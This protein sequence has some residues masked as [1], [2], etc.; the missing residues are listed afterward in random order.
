M[1]SLHRER[2]REIDMKF[3]TRR[4]IWLKAF[5]LAVV[6][7]LLVPL[8]AFAQSNTVTM[9]R[10]YNAS[11]GEHFFTSSLNEYETLGRI[12]WVKEGTAWAV[13]ENSDTPVYRLYNPNSGDHHY[14]TS[15]TEYD[16]LGRIGWVQEGIGWYSSG[17]SGVAVYRLFNPNVSVGTHHYTISQNEYDT[18]GRLGWVQEGVAWYGVADAAD[19][20]FHGLTTRTTIMG[21]SSV[22]VDQ[23]VNYYKS[24]GKTYPSDVYTQYG[25]VSIRDF[26]QILLEEANA[27]GVK[28]E[29]LFAQVMIETGGL[30]FGG[31]VKA[32]QCNFG[33]LGATDGGAAGADFS[34]NGSNS[35]RVGLRAQ[36][37]H[38]K[39]YASTAA[40]CNPCVDPRF[41]L[42]AR[43]SAPY[44]ENLGGGKWASDPDYASKLLRVINAL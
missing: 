40:L 33:G 18:L 26:C 37:Q 10:L 8:S 42:V 21:A 1:A 24:T 19:D 9:Y 34:G 7:A 5:F 36:A 4:S 30:Q 35:V 28:P 2:P 13:P 43:G 11:S 38:L 25:A 12:G 14:T 27:E 15:K 17:S 6:I 41:S 23:M 22:T 44:V 29:V 20:S 16:A 39:A 31:Q 3:R 32:N